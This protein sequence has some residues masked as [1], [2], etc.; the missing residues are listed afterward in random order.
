MIEVGWLTTELQE[1]SYLCLPG[2]AVTGVFCLMLAFMWVLRIS[3][4]VFMLA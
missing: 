3:L 1:S 4:K 2:T